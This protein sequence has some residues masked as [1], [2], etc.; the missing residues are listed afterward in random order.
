MRFDRSELH[1]RFA[2]MLSLPTPETDE[3]ESSRVST[4]SIVSLAAAETASEFRKI[5]KASVDLDHDPVKFARRSV[6]H[7]MTAEP[8]LA[9]F[10]VSQ[11]FIKIGQ[12][13]GEGA[14]SVF[15]RLD[16]ALHTLGFRQPRWCISF[17]LP[18]TGWDGRPHREIFTSR[19]WHRRG[20]PVH[21]S[22]CRQVSRGQ[23]GQAKASPWCEKHVT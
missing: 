15:G 6:V 7:C 21:P 23:T 2:L 12:G 18:S 17:T 22:E 9:T 16:H 20:P 1:L 13:C 11:R 14:A 3:T 5:S 10:E 4:H 8:F 19:S